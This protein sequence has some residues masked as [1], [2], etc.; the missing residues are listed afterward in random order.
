MT[1]IPTTCQFR[2]YGY[3][4]GKPIEHGHL[5]CKRHKQAKCASCGQP[6][7]HE[8]CDYCGQFVCVAPLCDERTYGTDESKPQFAD[9]HRIRK[10]EAENTRL[11]DCLAEALKALE[12]SLRSRKLGLADLQVDQDGRDGGE[13][14]KQV[15]MIERV[16]RAFVERLRGEGAVVWEEDIAVARAVIKAMREPTDAMVRANGTCSSE[17]GQR[18]LD[19]DARTTWRSMIDAALKEEKV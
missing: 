14:M 1:E 15:T 3:K 18:W 2:T 7:T 8:R 19:E 11:S 10:L 4:C 12:P 16:A 6:A 5:F 13:R 17:D 9:K